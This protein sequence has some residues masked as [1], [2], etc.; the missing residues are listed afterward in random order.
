M[1]RFARVAKFGYVRVET[2]GETA[3]GSRPFPPLSCRH[4]LT[5]VPAG[6]P[7]L[8][9]AH[10]PFEA[11]HPYAECGPLFVCAD[12]CARHPD[13]PDLPPI[14]TTSPDYLLKGYSADE[15]IVYGT[16]KVVAQAGI[17]AYA[18]QVLDDPRVRHIHVRSARNNC[19]QL[20]IAPD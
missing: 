9:V 20:R 16:D 15:R 4:C 12:A 10:R 13:G 17:A 8:I 19:Y 3:C 2:T 14:L 18:A 1:I 7:Y 6:A 5:D 11:L